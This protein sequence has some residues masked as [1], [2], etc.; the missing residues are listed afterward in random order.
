MEFS[1]SNLIQWN[2]HRIN[3]HKMPDARSLKLKV[4]NC[5]DFS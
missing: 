3:E 5:K 4:E 2:S 1:L